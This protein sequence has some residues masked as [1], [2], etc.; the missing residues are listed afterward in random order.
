[1]KLFLLICFFALPCVAQELVVG[2]EYR[3]YRDNKAHICRITKWLGGN[4]YEANERSKQLPAW[5]PSECK[6]LNGN[7]RWPQYIWKKEIEIINL[8]QFGRVVLIR[9]PNGDKPDNWRAQ[10]WNTQWI[11]ESERINDND[12]HE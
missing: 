5:G 9:K 1:M 6:D 11:P 2:G 12:E 10:I 4:F 7:K 3:L 8:A